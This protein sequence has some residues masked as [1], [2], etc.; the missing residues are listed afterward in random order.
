MINDPVRVLTIDNDY[1]LKYSIKHEGQH[2][3]DNVI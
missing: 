2:L 1:V 3:Y